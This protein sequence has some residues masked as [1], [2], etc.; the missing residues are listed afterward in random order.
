VSHADSG[1]P[2]RVWSTVRCPYFRISTAFM[3][4]S[5]LTLLERRGILSSANSRKVIDN[6]V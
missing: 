3:E 6:V 1:K 2:S 4:E 5:F